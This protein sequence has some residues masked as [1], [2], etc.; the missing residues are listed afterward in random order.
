MLKMQFYPLLLSAIYAPGYKL[1]LKTM[2]LMSKYMNIS[3]HMQNFCE[4]VLMC[5]QSYIS[6]CA[7]IKA[8]SSFI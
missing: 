1:A 7:R 6:M 5:S 8:L 2:E 4:T 3:A